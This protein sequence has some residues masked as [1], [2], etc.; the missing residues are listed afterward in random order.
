MAEEALKSAE[1][2]LQDVLNKANAKG[3]T[4]EQ[5][6]TACEAACRL[7]GGL[8][9]VGT[10]HRVRHEAL[11]APFATLLCMRSLLLV[12]TFNTRTLSEA[13]KN[14]P[15]AF[16][17]HA[18]GSDQAALRFLRAGIRHHC[19]TAS[20]QHLAA[21]GLVHDERCLPQLDPKTLAHLPV[22][23]SRSTFSD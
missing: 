14:M 23:F 21:L 18:S 4:R 20:L 15:H 12:T 7:V 22:N 5:V 11:A 3:A 8:D 19:P 9:L 16:V 2:A 17:K 10:K 6:F 13:V 1:S